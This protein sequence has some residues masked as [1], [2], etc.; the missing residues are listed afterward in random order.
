[1]LFGEFAREMDSTEGFITLVLVV[2][3]PITGDITDLMTVSFVER[4]ILRERL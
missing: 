1:M 3:M 2:R 4:Q